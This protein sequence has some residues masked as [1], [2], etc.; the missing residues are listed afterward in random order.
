MLIPTFLFQPAYLPCVGRLQR[1]TVIKLSLTRLMTPVAAAV[2][3]VIML[4]EQSAPPLTL[5]RS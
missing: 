4:L 1:T 3:Y 5:L 2:P